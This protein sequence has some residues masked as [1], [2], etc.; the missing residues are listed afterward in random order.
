MINHD[1]QPLLN[2]DIITQQCN[3]DEF[4]SPPWLRL[5]PDYDSVRHLIVVAEDGVGEFWHGSRLSIARFSMTHFWLK[6][7]ILLVLAWIYLADGCK[8]LCLLA[9]ISNHDCWWSFFQV[10]AVQTWSYGCSHTSSEPR[11]ISG[12]GIGALIIGIHFL[13]CS[14]TIKIC[15]NPTTV[16]SMF[17][18]AFITPMIGRL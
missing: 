12:Q 7:M 9:F 10:M 6:P 4:G 1:Y 11:S 8:W 14:A 17:P 13:H 15:S 2:P 16:M 3:L 5:P 18:V